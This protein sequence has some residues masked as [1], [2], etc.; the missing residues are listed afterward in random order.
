MFL[1]ELPEKRHFFMLLDVTQVGKSK[2]KNEGN[3]SSSYVAEFDKT[4]T[5]S[6]LK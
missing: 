4:I 5:Q 2:G 1:F 6:T 3:L